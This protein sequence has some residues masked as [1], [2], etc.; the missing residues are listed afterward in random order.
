MRSFCQKLLIPFLAFLISGKDTSILLPVS[1]T[2]RYE[3]LSVLASGLPPIHMGWEAAS[4]TPVAS[5][6][7]LS[8]LPSMLS[9]AA[10]VISFKCQSDQATLQLRALP[11]TALI[12][13]V[14][15]EKDRLSLDHL[16]VLE[17][18]MCSENKK[19][20]QRGSC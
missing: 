17:S 12:P 16:I 3:A 13:G 8:P 1:P 20:A 5:L 10:T 14:E 6:I 2:S 4:L 11:C 9:R 19:P 7:Q 18:N 15:Q